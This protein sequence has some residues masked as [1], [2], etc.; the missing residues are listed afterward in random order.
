M[1]ALLCCGLL[2][3]CAPCAAADFGVVT[4]ADPGS[5]VLR[6]ATWY[7]VAPGVRVED[8]DIVDAG[9]R[10]QLQIELRAG[11]ILNVV[12]PATLQIVRTS[13]AGTPS[14]VTLQRGWVKAVAKPPGLRI[15]TPAA[16]VVQADGVIVLRAST[17]PELFV[18]SGTARLIEV[19]PNGAEGVAHEVK[20]GEHVTRSA[21]ER[22]AIAPG[23]PKAFVDAMPKHYVDALPTLAAK[24]KTATPPVVERDISYAEAQ[25]WLA[26]RDRAAFERRFAS[27]LRDPA[28]RRAVEPNVAR[29]PMWDRMLHPD[30]YA[31]KQPAAAAR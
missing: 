19:G 29:Y 10:A 8:A 9:E 15:Q 11:S 5:R 6:G 3:V 17:P 23:A 4:L 7:K 25:P 21:D 31:P 14:V 24:H 27:R 22:Y 26:G 2:F 13:T 28:F 12:G 20:R 30:K 1:R 16:N 18:E